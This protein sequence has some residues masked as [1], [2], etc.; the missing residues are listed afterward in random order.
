MSGRSRSRFV[1]ALRRALPLC[2][3]ITTIAA[4]ALN[5]FGCSPTASRSSLVSAADPAAAVE[6]VTY[7]SVLGDFSKGR[8]V[9]PGPW[10]NRSEGTNPASTPTK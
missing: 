5:A 2:G 3:R 7:R 10:S 8:P 6:A 9:E 4:V 1:A